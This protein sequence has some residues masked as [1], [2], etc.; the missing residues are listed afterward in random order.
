M[1]RLSPVSRSNL[2][3]RLR[4]LRFEG[5]FAGGSH[6]FMLRK[7]RRLILP[8]PHRSEIS[9]DLLRRILRQAGVTIQE[10]QASES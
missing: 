6:Q 4:Q 8:N 7:N 9:V 10:W 1:A 3:R 2:I 5:P